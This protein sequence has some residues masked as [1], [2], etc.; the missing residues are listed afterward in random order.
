VRSPL[1]R[2]LA[3]VLLLPAAGGALALSACGGNDNDQNAEKLIDRAFRHPIKSADLKLGAQV[4]VKGSTALNRPIRIQAS[5]PYKTNK[6]RL[7]SLDIALNVS[8]GGGQTISTGF[9]STG[10][11]SFVKFQDVYYEEPRSQVDRANRALGRAGARRGSLKSLG[12]N[13]RSWLRGAKE[14]GDEDVAGVKT[15]HVSGSLD[16][17]NLLRDFNNF[18][19]RQGSSLGAASGQTPPQPLTKTDIKKVSDVVKDP[20]FDLYV[21]KSDDTVHRVSGRLELSVPEKS[22]ASVGGIKS[23]TLEFSVELRNVNGNQKV[24]A[25]ARARPISD[26]TNSLGAGAL[27]GLGGGTGGTQTPGGSSGGGTSTT[28]S[29]DAFKKYANCLDKAKSQD[30]AALQRCAKLLR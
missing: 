18:I 6:G 13:P 17:K 24:V 11:R 2:L 1:R 21:G 3:A 10:R 29:S 23:G 14:E 15:T 19:K 30:T 27:G 9:L 4:Q 26:L 5:G 16:V 25:P 20:H 12:L 22:R 28:P 8:A 7:P